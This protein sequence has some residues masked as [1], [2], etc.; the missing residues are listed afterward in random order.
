MKHQC[1]SVWHTN[2]KPA[3]DQDYCKDVGYTAIIFI[4]FIHLRAFNEYCNLFNPIPLGIF[5]YARYDKTTDKLQTSICCSRACTLIIS[6]SLR[7][8]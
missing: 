8:R 3:R 4:S 1:F 2:Y 7:I 5:G 6:S